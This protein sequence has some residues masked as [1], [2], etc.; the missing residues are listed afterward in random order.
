MPYEE[1]IVERY[2]AVFALAEQGVAGEKENA[3]RIRAKMEQMYP[4]IREQAFPP[5]PQDEGFDPS[6]TDDALWFRDDD[7]GRYVPLDAA[8]HAAIA[9]GV[10]RL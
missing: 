3:L 8:I 1:K 10:K 5:P 4:G 9:S 2:K 7:A 6:R